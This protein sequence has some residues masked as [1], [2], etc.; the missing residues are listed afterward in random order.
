MQS[1]QK[2]WPLR[3][4]LAICCDK[5]NADYQLAWR[6]FLRR[7]KLF[8]YQIITHRCINWRVSRLRRQISDV[9]NDIVSDVLVILNQ[10]LDQYRE[11]ED[12]KRFRL[13]LGTI[14]NRA[15]GR[16]LKR[17]FSTEIAEQDPEE[18]HNYIHGLAFDS[19]WELYETI[20]RQL[21]AA[22]SLKKQHLERDINI[23]Q[24]Y[25][26]SD[27]SQ[28]MILTH[29]CYT[30]IGHRVIDN[31]INRLREQLRTDKMHAD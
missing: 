1:Q 11:R 13:W 15:T 14:C 31:V 2:Q 6:E 27:L 5:K 26:W 3:Q 23:F 28:C 24:F 12:D 30:E 25:I 9:V 7:Y 29:P 22:G 16:Y 18:F 17:E 8:I 10:S 19:R 4:L 21:R 20:V